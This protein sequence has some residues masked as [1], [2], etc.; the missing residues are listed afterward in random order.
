MPSAFHH[1]VM[2]YKVAIREIESRVGVLS[3]PDTTKNLTH[4]ALEYVNRQKLLIVGL[5]SL[6]EARLYLEVQNYT[7]PESIED[8]P[9]QGITRLKSFLS[10]TGIVNFGHLNEW[11]KF[12]LIYKIRNS[13]IHSYGGLVFDSDVQG[14]ESAVADLAF[15]PLLEGTRIRI[16]PE[17]LYQTLDIVSNLID[18]IDSQVTSSTAA[19]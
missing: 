12:R 6:I 4:E 3:K 7:G 14:I 13:I 18:E 11:P 5:C 16:R 15:E 19:T 17:H 9:G 10:K 2:S 1:E 8:E